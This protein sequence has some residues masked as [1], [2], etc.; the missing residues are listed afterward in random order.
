MYVP[1]QANSFIDAAT[2]K[3]VTVDPASPNPLAP[4]FLDENCDK[5]TDA[6]SV[7]PEVSEV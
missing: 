6:S 1:E 4:D 7:R 5:L 2:G 3:V